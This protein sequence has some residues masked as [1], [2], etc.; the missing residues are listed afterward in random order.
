MV[1]KLRFVPFFA[2]FPS[3]LDAW[4]KNEECV[5]VMSGISH[6]TVVKPELYLGVQP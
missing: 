2:L 1:K 5:L 4:K 6:A 3:L